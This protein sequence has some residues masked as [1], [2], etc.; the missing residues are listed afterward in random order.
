LRWAVSTGA[1]CDELRLCGRPGL[2]E[3]TLTRPDLYATYYLA[4]FKLLLAKP[5]CELEVGTSNQPIPVHFSFAEHEHMEGEMS[6][7]RRM[8]MRDVF[9][10]PDLT[11]MDDGIAN[12]TL[13]PGRASRNRCRCSPLPRMDYSLQRL[14]HYSGTSPAGFRTTCCSPTTSSTLTSSCAGPR[15]NAKPGQ[16]LRRFCRTRQRGHAPRRFAR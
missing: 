14:R 7:E 5:R 2:Y 12:G 8:L 1:T 3:T 16:P 4:Q 15:R 11:A 9:D 13:S 10:L 6:A